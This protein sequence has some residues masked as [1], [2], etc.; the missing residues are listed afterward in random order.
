LPCLSQNGYIHLSPIGVSIPTI[1]DGVF[2]LSSN[3]KQQIVIEAK[4]ISYQINDNQSLVRGGCLIA[5]LLFENYTTRVDSLDPTL[6]F[7]WITKQKF[8]YDIMARPV[9]Y[10]ELNS[11]R[12]EAKMQVEFLMKLWP[13]MALNI[14][15]LNNTFVPVYSKNRN[16]SISSTSDSFWGAMLLSQ[17]ETELFCES[18]V[19]EHSHNVMF[20]MLEMNKL[21]LNDGL[22]S[23]NFYSP[24]RPDARHVYGIFHAVYVFDRV[25]EYY[26]L[27]LKNKPNSVSI[28]TRLALFTER[29]K[30]GI[31][32]LEQSA[33]LTKNGIALI[34]ELKNNCVKWNNL[35]INA[36]LEEVKMIII[37]H[38]KKWCVDNPNANRPKNIF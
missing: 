17:V 36:N 4:N 2:L 19:H 26:S 27:L 23:T 24:W 18:L 32:V 7:H 12:L 13:E 33:Q 37:D 8:P 6:N 3:V 29:I 14:I 15:E 34:H 22:S 1:S 38:Y 28:A 30:I 20:A 10:E 16:V 21:L 5:P 31:I 35:T 25:C 11:W 9:S